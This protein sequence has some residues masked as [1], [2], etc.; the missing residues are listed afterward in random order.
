MIRMSDKQKRGAAALIRAS[1][2]NY[3]EGNCLVLSGEDYISCPQVVNNSLICKYFR[4]A[5]LPADKLLHAQIMSS[6]SV[7]AC[8]V[9][10]KPFRAVSNRAKFCSHCAKIERNKRQREYMRSKVG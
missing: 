4:E 5:V 8:M 2:A 9:C 7:K 1:C 10:G 6:D 3:W